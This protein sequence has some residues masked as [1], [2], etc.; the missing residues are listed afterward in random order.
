MHHCLQ[1]LA[2]EDVGELFH[3]AHLVERAVGIID[4]AGAVEDV[5]GQSVFG[6]KDFG[7]GPVVA[8]HG[9]LHPGDARRDVFAER[10]AE[11]MHPEP[12]LPI[13]HHGL[14]VVG[15]AFRVFGRV[16][17]GFLGWA[18]G[19]AHWCFEATA[20]RGAHRLDIV[21]ADGWCQSAIEQIGIAQ[22]RACVMNLLCRGREETREYQ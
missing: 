6:E 22:R 8:V 15:P 12:A 16:E 18:N 17:H 3:G 9:T 14:V 21:H 19:G 1:P 20:S 2:L 10:V 13:G 7:S 5:G 11:E 4:L